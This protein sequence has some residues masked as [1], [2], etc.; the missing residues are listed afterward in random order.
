MLSMNFKINPR[1]FRIAII[2]ALVLIIIYFLYLV[3]IILPPFFLSIILAYLLNPLVSYLETKGFKRSLSILIVYASVLAGLFIVIFYG[4][5]I[6]I[7]EI[8][9]FAETIP[10]IT[11]QMQDIVKEFYISF[12]RIEIPESI[13]QVIN[14]TIVSLE[15]TL[16]STIDAI[17]ERMLGIFSGLVV[18]LIA[19]ILAFYLLNDKKNICARFLSIF[20]AAWR[21]EIN[22]LWKEID[23]VLMKFVR[24][25][26]L[27]ALLVGLLT[28][29][30]LSLIN[31][32]FAILLG[33][34]AG[35]FDLIPYFGPIIGV[36]PALFIA[37]LDSKIKALYVI[38]L[39]VVVQQ[40]ESNVLSPKIL[41]ESV[42]LHPITV[43]FVVLAGGHLFGFI[44]LMAAVPVT[45]VMRIV[46]NYWMDKIIT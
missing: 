24:G 4:F 5:P 38:I 40:I 13:R 22:Q 12:Q 43:I 26:L 46:I 3:R 6:V 19:P 15:E 7:K 35:V 39:M 31:V 2:I 44:G 20:P 11:R 25:H 34:I 36:I 41:G 16:I 37:L 14:E 42:G 28:I 10:A 33:I 29:I 23:R 27:V 21:R 1:L 32:K 18:F 45:A 9:T 17:A 8:T 30:G